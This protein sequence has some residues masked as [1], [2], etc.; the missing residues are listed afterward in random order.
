MANDIE[1]MLNQLEDLRSLVDVIN[2]KFDE[3]RDSILT[4]EIREQLAEMEAERRT[5]LD[6]AQAGIAQV[7]ATIKADVIAAGCTFKSA[8][9]MA[10]YNKPRVTWDSRGLSGYA[11]AHPEIDA[12]CKV[13]DPS[14]TIRIR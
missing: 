6:A 5:A 14:V 8:N 4:P 12:F 13:G 10:V 9:L 3:L 11:V 2:M 7:E 1:G